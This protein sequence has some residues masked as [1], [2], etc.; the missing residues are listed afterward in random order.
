M[1]DF[2]GHTF[3]IRRQKPAAGMFYLVRNSATGKSELRRA[4]RAFRRD[5]RRCFVEVPNTVAATSTGHPDLDA[6]AAFVR[7]QG[8]EYA[9]ATFPS[10]MTVEIGQ[11]YEA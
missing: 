11:R 3:T 7:E 4:E 9:K 8:S 1:A 10:G 2:T 6:F 5:S